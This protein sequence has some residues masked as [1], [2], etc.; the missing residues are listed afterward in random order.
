M[1]A[2]GKPWHEWAQEIKEAF[3]LDAFGQ[4]YGF[5][6]K[7]VKSMDIYDKQVL[8]AIMSGECD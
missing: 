7:T 2:P 3:E 5:N 1:I 4:R 6:P 8:K